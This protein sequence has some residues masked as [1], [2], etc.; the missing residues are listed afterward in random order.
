V[1]DISDFASNGRN[2]LSISPR[3][4]RSTDDYD[5]EPRAN[6]VALRNRAMV[7]KVNRL[8]RL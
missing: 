3:K 1:A 4:T 8:F 6:V 7:V 2:R 5:T